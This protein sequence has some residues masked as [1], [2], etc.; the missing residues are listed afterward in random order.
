MSASPLHLH[1]GV[2]VIPDPSAASALLGTGSYGTVYAGV[3]R[4]LTSERTV[5]IKMHDDAFLLDREHK[6]YTYVWAQLKRGHA[7]TLRVPRLLWSGTTDDGAQRVL[8]MERLGDSLDKLFDRDQKDWGQPTVCW[9]ACEALR[10]LQ[11]LHALGLVHRDIKPD[12][13]AVG[14]TPEHRTHLY[15]FDF[16]LSSQFLDRSGK[17]HPVRT[18]LSLIGTMRYASMNNHEGTLQSRRDDLQALCY[19]LLYFW[20]GTLPWKHATKQLDTRADKNR[21]LLKHK[22]QLH[23]QALGGDPI[24]VATMMSHDTPSPS[25]VTYNVPEP[26]HAFYTYVHT[27]A[28]DETPDYA[29]WIA[30]FEALSEHT[31]TLPDWVYGKVVRQPVAPQQQAQAP[32]ATA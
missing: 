8:V 27:L 2:F 12:N 30:H 25:H 23:V 32:N 16:G 29:K 26:L 13:F 4:L 9:V 24:E 10:L 6:V 3:Q 11:G 31:T 1:N 19:V 18:G 22:R 7:P 28:Y 20:N 15:L 5:A 17:H 21:V 14:Y